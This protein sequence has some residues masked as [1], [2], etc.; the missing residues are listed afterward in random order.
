M[1]GSYVL[2]YRVTSMSAV[3]FGGKDCMISSRVTGLCDLKRNAV[4]GLS[5]F[6]FIAL[7]LRSCSSYCFLCSAK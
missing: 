1:A 5:S 6:A 2:K 7:T 4:P 3:G